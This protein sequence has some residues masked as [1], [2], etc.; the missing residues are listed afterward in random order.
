MKSINGPIIHAFLHSETQDGKSLL[1]A[2]FA[3]ATAL[4]K[5]YLKRIRNNRLNKITSPNE[6]AYGLADLGG[7]QNCGIQLVVFD[8]DVC[9]K[10]VTILEKY[11][12]R[13]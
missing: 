10:L 3:H 13:E 4:L 7:L 8:E 6:L 2:H 1:D 5:R 11:K 9:K 12:A